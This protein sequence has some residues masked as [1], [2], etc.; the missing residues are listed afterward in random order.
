[1]K[2]ALSVD[3]GKTCISASALRA[4]PEKFVTSKWFPV[5]T[6]PSEKVIYILTVSE[7]LLPF[8]RLRIDSY[9]LRHRLF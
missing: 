8:L 9:F 1:M 3:S 6:L 5:T 2:T 7:C 4:G